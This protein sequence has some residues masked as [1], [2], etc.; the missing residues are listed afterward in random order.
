MN[1]YFES[2]PFKFVISVF[3]GVWGVFVLVCILNYNAIIGDTVASL[4]ALAGTFIFIA[5]LVIIYGFVKYRKE[6]TQ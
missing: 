1:S 5:H 6:K 4:S 2:D 3:T